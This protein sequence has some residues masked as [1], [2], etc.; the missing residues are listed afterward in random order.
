MTGT[1]PHDEVSTRAG[2]S[3]PGGRSLFGIT[4]VHAVAEFSAWIA[5]LVVAFDR[6]GAGAT[7]LAVA[8]QLIPA[9]VLAPI[10]T[11]AGDRFPR[12]L[13][14]VTAFTAL[15]ASAAGLA[16]VLAADATLIVI[17]ALA[18]AFTVALCSTPGTVASLLVHHART[19]M[20]LMHWNV[21][22]SFVRAA[23]SLLGP[24]LTAIVLAV[25]TPA[26]VF[27][28]L[29]IICAAAAATIALR[30][31][32]D[33][34][35]PSTLRLQAI[36][37][38]SVDGLRYVAS[39]P[40][41]RRTI[42]F[43]AATEMLMG[44]LDV[45]FV[46]VAFDQLGLG[47]SATALIAAAFAA[48]ALVGSVSVSRR[49]GWRLTSFISG[50]VLL[51][52]LPLTVLGE[53]SGIGVVMVLVG[54][55]GAGHALVEIGA[56]T[57]LQRTTSEVMTSRSFGVLDSSSLVGAA[58]GAAVAGAVI[59]DNDLTVAVVTIGIVSAAALLA[60]SLALRS[61]ERRA[62]SVDTALVDQLRTVSF[63]DPLPLPT[64]E[65]L[66]AGLERRSADAEERLVVQGDPGRD[67]FVL[68][69]GTVEVSI[70]GSV[71]GTMVAP[72]SFGEVALLHDDVR[73]ASVTA[74]T[75]CE[76]AVID[77]HHFLDAVERTASSH[78]EALAVAQQY[79]RP[80]NG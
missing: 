12:H 16:I 25:A 29:C 65:R 23:G 38:D 37:H 42:A 21:A 20:E 57:L 28:G 26:A 59:S 18:A 7:G 27:V 43:I 22:Q 74:T 49:T 45:V 3:L 67:F 51:A 76:L 32:P 46:A 2:G 64:L 52:T 5:V 4:F 14:L 78:R 13:V 31:P 70:D 62:Q 15:A 10:V 30:L 63:L 58:I 47:G 71:V 69:D 72:A 11:A 35:L 61:T 54:L 56:H 55:L 66:A 73:S 33:D 80:T 17:Y 9:A 6:G 50:G 34:R 75:P 8:V 40:G 79:R 68:L 77:Q 53:L 39:T 36:L 19:P 48:G 41:P 1:A 24:L 44:A 60:G